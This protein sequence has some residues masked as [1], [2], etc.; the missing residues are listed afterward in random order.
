MLLLLFQREDKQRQLHSPS[1]G[2]GLSSLLCGGAGG[3]LTTTCKGL[4][5]TSK[6]D[7][8]VPSYCSAQQHFI[9]SSSDA[10]YKQ[11]ETKT[12]LQCRA[13]GVIRTRDWCAGA[14][15]TL[16]LLCSTALAA[17]CPLPVVLL[18]PF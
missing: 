6:C 13:H 17:L 12:Q 18:S 7:R 16:P 4:C 5:L 8:A 2:S 10:S 1:E 14:F 3:S 15:C 9:S 11:V